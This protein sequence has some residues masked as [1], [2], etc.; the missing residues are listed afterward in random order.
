[1]TTKWTW[2]IVAMTCGL[3]LAASACDESDTVA[4]DG[5]TISLSATPATILLSNGIQARDVTIVATVYN[6]IGVPLP[7]QDVRF[8]T[9]SGSL[10]PPGN[11]PVETDDIGNALSILKGASATTTITA[12]SGKATKDISLQTVTCDIQS[13][14]LSESQLNFT[15]CNT[16]AEGGSFELTATVSDT[17]GAPC[18]G[19]QV[20][21]SVT[22][23]S[24]P[25]DEDVGID[26]SPGAVTTDSNGEATTTVSLA[27]DCSEDCPG[28]DCITSGQQIEASG[29]GV[30]STPATV[31]D[32]I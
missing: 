19:I 7:G 17:S 18:V 13:I 23:T 5:S 32:N 20:A 15:S 8:T 25:P 27:N 3:L 2:S 6:S 31:S 10:T 21:F 26:I 12:Q 14:S 1:M 11:T 29:G 16:G 30:T 4:P 24:D 28:K 9:N 22:T